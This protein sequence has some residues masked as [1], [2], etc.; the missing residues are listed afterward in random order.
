MQFIRQGRPSIKRKIEYKLT[1]FLT[2]SE[3]L[4]GETASDCKMS[5]DDSC[6]A[7]RFLGVVGVSGIA[8]PSFLLLPRAA[9]K[10]K[11]I[12]YQD[13]FFANNMKEILINSW[14]LQN[15]IV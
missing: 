11:V 12:I 6:A 4:N 13:V 3:R 2:A 15:F 8:S 14:H 1:S 10:C 9:P 5:S 7:L